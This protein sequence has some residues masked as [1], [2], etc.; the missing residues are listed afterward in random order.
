MR[1]PR[2]GNH[3]L[4]I[5]G[6]RG[7][8]LGLADQEAWNVRIGLEVADDRHHETPLESLLGGSIGH[9]LLVL[10][11]L[12][13]AR[14]IPGVSRQAE[15]GNGDSGEEEDADHGLALLA[16]TDSLR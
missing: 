6:D 9:P 10:R 7:L 16:V 11:H 15:A 4:H 5:G 2:F 13:G 1:D 8:R 14:Q 12:G 3:V